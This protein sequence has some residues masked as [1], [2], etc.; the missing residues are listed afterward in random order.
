MKARSTRSVLSFW[1][2]ASDVVVVV[3]S[4]AIVCTTRPRFAAGSTLPPRP[5]IFQL[6][7]KPEAAMAQENRV[8][9]M[10]SRTECCRE[11]VQGRDSNFSSL[12]G[13]VSDFEFTSIHRST[14]TN[15]PVREGSSVTKVSCY[16]Q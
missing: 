15:I 3:K 12:S 2:R 5:R 13:L 9:F 7:L 14:S 16:G 6:L 8:S 1:S 11:A 4:D 10:L